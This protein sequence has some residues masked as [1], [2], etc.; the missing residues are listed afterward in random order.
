MSG[1]LPSSSEPELPE[2]EPRVIGVDEDDAEDVLAALSSETARSLFAAVHETPATPSELADR[3]ETSLQNAQYHLEKLDEADLIEV[4]DTR[5][6]EKGREMKVLGPSGA[7]VVLFAGGEAESTEVKSAL[8]SLLGG[9]G[10]L[11]VA[12]LAVQQVV[13]NGIGALF[14]AGGAGGE[15]G[16]VETTSDVGAMD[17]QQEA[18]TTTTEAAVQYQADVV[19]GLPPGLLFFVGGALILA[20][21]AIW[22]YVRR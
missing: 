14:G 19:A 5:Y 1:L 4:V 17:V 8:A 20:L 3:T 7:P 13:G 16:A 10:V 9:V 15:D 21:A 12:S 2:G 22:W 6:S 11:A 18:A